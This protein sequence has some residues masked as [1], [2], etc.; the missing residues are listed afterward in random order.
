M[1]EEVKKKKSQIEEKKWRIEEGKEVA[2]TVKGLLS[3]EG[4][5]HQLDL[6][7]A[8]QLHVLTEVLAHRGL[9]LHVVGECL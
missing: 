4:L 3:L 6:V 1:D 8:L 2:L 7:H 9:H 5:H